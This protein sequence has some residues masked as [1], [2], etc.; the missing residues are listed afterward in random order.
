MK[1]L[2]IALV[3]LLAFSTSTVIA[4]DITNVAGASGIAVNGYDCVAFFTEGKPVN[5]N[6]EIS[7]KH[8]GA[9]Y[10]FASKEN[11]AKFEKDADKY[12]PQFGGYC[13]F[14]VSVGALFPIDINTW[15]IIDGKLYINLN[16]DIKKLFDKDHA[17]N[18]AKAVKNW[19]DLV[20]KNSK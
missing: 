12:A 10:F 16:P 13:A 7:F 5:G 18:L 11:K 19:P 1:S 6:P 8:H 20:K 4:A 2:L 3:S 15:Q 9:V 14:G 17:A